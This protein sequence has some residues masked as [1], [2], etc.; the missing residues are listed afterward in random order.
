MFIANAT[1]PRVQ[2]FLHA[3]F[4]PIYEIALLFSCITAYKQPPPS[5]IIDS[6]LVLSDSVN[7]IHTR[8]GVHECCR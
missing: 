8:D 1:V 6:T 2:P 5:L 3:N 7:M 4:S